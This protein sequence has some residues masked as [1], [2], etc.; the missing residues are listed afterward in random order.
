M[1][2]TAVSSLLGRAGE[3]FVAV[4]GSNQSALETVLLKRRVMMPCWLSLKHPTRIDTPSQVGT[5]LGVLAST[6][7]RSS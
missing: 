5:C 3:H 1:V 2:W 6:P 7:D 4:F